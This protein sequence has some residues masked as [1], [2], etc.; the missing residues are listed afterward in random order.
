MEKYNRYW[1][2]T[3]A[4][5]SDATF[6]YKLVRSYFYY[7]NMVS[8]GLSE[9]QHSIL[10]KDIT[11][12]GHDHTCKLA[13]LDQVNALYYSYRSGPV[14]QAE[15]ALHKELVNTI[16]YHPRSFQVLQKNPSFSAHLSS[17][18]ERMK[19]ELEY[20][21]PMI[22]SYTVLTSARRFFV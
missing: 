17:I 7:L 9:A 16:W 15:I 11:A 21:K 10:Q 2:S 3:T 12:P 18:E 14:D 19:G 5:R 1:G 20:S 8:N 22:Q 13:L 4:L 6:M